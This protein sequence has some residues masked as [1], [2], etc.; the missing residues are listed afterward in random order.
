MPADYEVIQVVGTVG[1][2][3]LDRDAT[4][5]FDRIEFIQGLCAEGEYDDIDR[6][7]EWYI[8]NVLPK[9]SDGS[10]GGFDDRKL[11]IH[12]I[13]LEDDALVVEQGITHYGDFAEELER[14]DEDNYALQAEAIAALGE[15]WAFFSRISGVGGV[16]F[17][18]EGHF[19]VGVRSPQTDAPGSLD[20]VSGHRAY[21]EDPN[22]NALEE[23]LN[24][25]MLRKRGVPADAIVGRK[26]IG[27]YGHP[28]RG[29]FDFAYL[30]WTDLPDTKFEEHAGGD[31]QNQLVRVS[32]MEDVER[33]LQEGKAPGS[34]KSLP[35]HY[36]LRGSLEQLTAEDFRPR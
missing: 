33:I 9:I 34:D 13:R 29:D 25:A 10:E 1:T 16:V 5:A 7:R 19:Y 12:D 8:A 15:R 36:T 6:S 11:R 4:S 30:V 2:F 35:L 3:A 27:A 26:F 23:D 31:L 21:Q 22:V 17:S 28:A 18:K 32:S 14:S 24:D 20:A